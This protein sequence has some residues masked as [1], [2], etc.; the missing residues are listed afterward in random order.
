[1]KLKIIA[2]IEDGVI[3]VNKNNIFCFRE[4]SL[5]DDKGEDSLCQSDKGIYIGQI[6]TEKNHGEADTYWRYNNRKTRN[7]G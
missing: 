1:M 6:L 5:R 3:A 4:N 2:I 7:S